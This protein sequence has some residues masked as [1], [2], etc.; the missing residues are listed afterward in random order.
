ML[1]AD[2]MRFG[3]AN[4]EVIWDGLRPPR[5][6]RRRRRRRTPTPATRRRASPR[7]TANAAVTVEPCDR[8]H[9]RQGQVYVGHYE[10]RAT[11]VAD[12]DPSA[13]STARPRAFAPGTY[14]MVVAARDHRASPRFTDHRAGTAQAVTEPIGDAQPTW[15]P[16]ANG[17]QGDRPPAPGS[18]NADVAH[19]RH[20]G[21]QLGRRQPTHERRRA[22]PLRRGRPGRRRSQTIR[23]GPRQR[24]AA[25]GAG[26]PATD[27]PLGARRRPRTRAPASPRCGSSRS[28]SASRA[29]P[30]HGA[31]WTRRLHL[32]GR[33][34]PG[35][36]P[37]PVAPNLTLRTVRRAATG[38]GRGASAW[39][40]WRT[41]APGTPATPASRTTTRPTAPTARPAS[42]RGTTVQAAELQVLLTP[43]TSC[44]RARAR[45]RTV[46]SSMA[47]G[48]AAGPHLTSAMAE[49]G[50][51]CREPTSVGS[52][53]WS[54]AFQ[55][56]TS[57][58]SS[59]EARY[60]TKAAVGEPFEVTA[61]V[62]REG[63]DEHRR[64]GRAHRSRGGPTAPLAHA[65]GPCRGPDRYRATVVADTEGAWGFE[66]HGWSDP[67]ATWHHHAEIKVPG[68]HRHRADVHRGRA[69]AGEGGRRDLD[70]QPTPRSLL[71]AAKA[72]RDSDR[73]DAVPPGRRQR[74]PR[75][76]TCWPPHPVRELLTVAGPFPFYVDRRAG[77]LQL[78]VR[79]LP[80][81]RGRLRRHR[82]RGGQRHV[83]D[84]RRATPGRRR[85]WAS[86]SSTC[87][88]IHPIGADQPQ[89]PQQHP[90]PRPGGPRL[91]RGPSARRR[92]A[93]TRST[94][95]S[96]RSRTST[97]SS[98]AAGGARPR[99]GPRPRAPG[100]PG[101]PV[102]HRA[103]GVVHHPRRRHHRLRREPAEEVPGHLPAQLR[104]RPRG[105]LRRDAPDRP[106]LDEPRGPRLPR[107]QPAH[108][109]GRVLGVAARPRCGRPTPT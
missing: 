47:T 5:H 38:P 53:T 105:Q 4:Q 84:R 107:R 71:D 102:G 61:L 96:A 50:G 55:S 3:G 66:I 56:S 35:A 18:L 43:L 60:P 74:A 67:Y 20:R 33:R 13:R 22:P 104:Q 103:P 62:I 25:P 85:R 77:A 87:R 54:D 29:A 41:S 12:T 82:R 106:A 90:R 23:A 45:R 83:Q 64:R 73:P 81:L 75:S 15:P 11:P 30:T 32:A 57:R 37:G 36:A 109:A 44:R 92:A 42:D 94:P 9:Q 68:G 51:G 2:R 52:R 24:D 46:C 88:P 63:H 8:R 99:G 58:P 80:P 91:A 10:A 76:S 101:P 98:R 40:P 48:P 93:T 1:A 31:T 86:T 27:V 79:V 34:L 100:R 95:T 17:A 7:R 97:P 21:H 89:G 16:P 69:A 72:L 19:R 28:R 78:V 59:K 6:G 26:Q 39:S 65:A 49:T 108:Q 70:G 14:Q